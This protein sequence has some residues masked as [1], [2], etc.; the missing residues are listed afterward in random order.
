MN[1][2]ILGGGAFAL[3]WWLGRRQMESGMT[4]GAFRAGYTR[5]ATLRPSRRAGGGKR[6]RDCFPN[7]DVFG[8]VQDRHTCYPTKIDANNLT[9]GFPYPSCLPGGQIPDSQGGA[10]IPVPMNACPED[11]STADAVAPAA[12]TGWGHYVG[13][14][15]G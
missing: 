8:A 5:T 2:W 9:H 15:Y 14:P 3:G 10:N 4:G 13:Y 11:L 7:V 1:A 12:V 6:M